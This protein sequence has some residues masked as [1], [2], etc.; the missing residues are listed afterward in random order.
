MGIIIIP[1][2]S[3]VMRGL[4]LE[5]E[6]GQAV[7]EVAHLFE[8]IS[9]YL[10]VAMAHT[11]QPDNSIVNEVIYQGILAHSEHETAAHGGRQDIRVDEL[12]RWV[13]QQ[14]T[15]L[16]A[17]SIFIMRIAYAQALADLADENVII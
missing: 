10:S 8:H 9:R 16:A 17:Y 7:D 14:H 1:Y 2:T 4:V 6:V 15:F 13:E 12:C 5:S 11:I 3:V